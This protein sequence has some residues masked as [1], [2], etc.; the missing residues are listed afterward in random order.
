MTA[1]EIREA[2]ID[3]QK[4]PISTDSKIKAE[5]AA[6]IAELNEH[7]KEL[8]DRQSTKTTKG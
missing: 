3:Q 6:Q 4:F 7:L 2:Y 8:L 5:I 1:Q